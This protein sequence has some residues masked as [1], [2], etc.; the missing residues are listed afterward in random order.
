[1]HPQNHKGGRKFATTDKFIIDEDDYAFV[2]KG[3]LYRLMDCLNFNS[4]KRTLTFDSKEYETYKD[5]G[6]KIMH[7]LPANEKLMNVTILMPD[8]TEIKCVGESGL[9]DVKVDDVIQAERFGFMRLDRKE[10]D[11]SGKDKL[12]FWYTHQ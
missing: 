10:K 12:F 2:K 4:S 3:G 9:K 1:L 11:A 5:K 8:N 6:K 7:W